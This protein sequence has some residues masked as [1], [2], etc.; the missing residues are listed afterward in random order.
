MPLFDEA[1]TRSLLDQLFSESRLY[2]NSKDYLDLL[3]FV[4]RLRN[5]APFN[6]MLLQ[7]Q[8]PGL[9]YAASAHDWRER[10]GCYPKDGARPLLILWPFGPVALVYDVMDVEG[11]PLPEDV[12]NLIAVGAI[13][14]TRMRGFGSLLSGK[15]IECRWVDEGDNH[16]GLIRRMPGTAEDAVIRFHIRINKNHSAPVQFSTLAHELAHLALGH[17]GPDKRLRVPPRPIPDQA[18]RELEAESA[19]FIVCKRNGVEV[20]SQSYLSNFVKASGDAESIDIYRV[21]LA[22]GRVE[23]WLDLADRTKFK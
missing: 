4:S 19:A 10:F 20:K 3:N 13:D 9:S 22:A 12:A 17:L 18:Q 6:A 1:A 14:E 21:M 8:K 2:R 23:E 7:V 5:F 11:G 15:G 16:A